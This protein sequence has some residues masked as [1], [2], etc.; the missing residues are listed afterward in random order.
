VLYPEGPF[1][2]AALGATLREHGVDTL[3]LTA[4]LFHLVIDEAPEILSGV[5]YLLAGGD[6]LSPDHIA[7]ARQALPETTIVNGYGPTESTTFACCYPIPAGPC[8]DRIPIGAPIANTRAFVLDGGLEPVPPGL[9]GELFLAGDGLARGYHQR[10]DLTAE[11][12]LPCPFG[13]QPGARMYRTGDLVCWLDGGVLDFLGRRDNQVKLRGFRIETGE[14]EAVLLQHAQVEEAAVVVRSGAAG[15]QLVAYVR[16]VGKEGATADV[17]ETLGQDVHAFLSERLPAYMVPTQ[18]VPL[19]TLPLTPNQKVDR[20]ALA[21]L[22][23]ATLTGTETYVAPATPTE[24]ALAEILRE[25]LAVERVGMRDNFFEL[26]GHSLVVP[27]AIS[28]IEARF[29]MKLPYEV[30]MNSRDIGEFAQRLDKL[31]LLD[32][33]DA[34]A[35]DEGDD[36]MEMEL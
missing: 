31:L 28:R 10:G 5:R 34:M 33:P 9:P 17:I 13:S 7:R 24:Q 20:R 25:L 36:L 32:N 23:P 14:I 27:V 8:P 6:V 12:F 16:A 4:A 29:D 21:A 35:G 18:V 26:G 11:R 1:H 22:D 30:L 19:P 15:K 2:P 3:W